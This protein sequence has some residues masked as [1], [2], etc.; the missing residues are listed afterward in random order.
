MIVCLWKD[1]VGSQSLSGHYHDS[2]YCH[3]SCIFSMN[4]PPYLYSSPNEMLWYLQPF[5]WLGLAVSE[6]FQTLNARMHII[7]HRLRCHNVI[8]MFYLESWLSMESILLLIEFHYFFSW[9]ASDKLISRWLEFIILF[10][11]GEISSFHFLFV[12]LQDSF[13]NKIKWSWSPVFL[14][15]TR[16]DHLSI[17]R[18]LR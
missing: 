13:P 9:H 17:M 8:K 16:R 14:E 11:K 5:S 10:Y 1:K 15:L 6:H 7:I 3:F 18:K 2:C 12:F 4:V